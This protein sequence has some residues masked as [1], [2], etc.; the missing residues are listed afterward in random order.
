MIVLCSYGML[1]K[2][3]GIYVHW[4]DATLFHGG[5]E[6]LTQYLI[7]AIKCIL[8]QNMTVLAQQGLKG[9]VML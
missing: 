7:I 4:V 3:P 9:S 6:K 1:A 5:S 8:L 2:L